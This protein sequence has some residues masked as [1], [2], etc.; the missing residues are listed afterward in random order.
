MV[1]VVV[2]LNDVVFIAAL[3]LADRTLIG[4]KHLMKHFVY[5]LILLTLVVS[6]GVA[7]QAAKPSPTFSTDG[8]WS[9]AFHG[10]SDPLNQ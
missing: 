10:G 5:A 2:R 3:L 6:I 8:K 9:F 1:G 4:R 7:Q